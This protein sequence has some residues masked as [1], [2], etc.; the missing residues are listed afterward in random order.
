MKIV[1][2][3]KKPVLTARYGRLPS[4]MTVDVDDTTGLFLVAEGVAVPLEVKEAQD[5][6]LPDAGMV[7]QS[8]ALPA[9]PASPLPTLKPSKRP[10]KSA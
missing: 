2:K 4:G 5:R 8:F 3:S 7:E 10:K 1:I 6:P 9:A